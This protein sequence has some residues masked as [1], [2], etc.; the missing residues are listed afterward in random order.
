MKSSPCYE[1]SLSRNYLKV[2]KLDLF[3][4]TY[5]RGKP[6]E[7]RIDG[8]QLGDINL[9]VGKNATGK[10]RIVR[11]IY[12][13]SELL[14]DGGKLGN[15]PRKYEWH[16]LF[17][18][19]SE[20]QTGYFLTI[21]NGYITQE[22]LEIGKKIFL[23]R[24]KTGEGTIYA[25]ELNKDI[26]FQ[27]PTTELA[28]VKRRD[29]IQ[30]P[31]L[32]S[33]YQWASSLRFYEFGTQLGKDTIARI[34]KK[35]KLDRSNIDLKN[36]ES[37]I[38]VFMLGKREIGKKFIDKIIEDMKKINYYIETIGTQIP[39]SIDFVELDNQDTLSHFLCIKEKGL[40]AITEQS[41]MSQGM[42]RVLSLLIQINYSLLSSKPSCILIDDI[43]EGL[44]FQRSSAIIKLLIEKAKTGLIKLIMTTNDEN[45]MNGVPLEYW[46]VIE[47]QPGVAK[48]HNYSNSPE[49]FEQFKHIG[50]NNFDFFAS[51]FYL[52]KPDSEE[53]ID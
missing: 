3:E 33:I 27:T 12:L 19:D 4:Y 28:V 23:Q 45:I 42:F 40:S 51:E 48:L 52:Q 17:D 21:K 44:D 32:E 9:I 34:P 47:R 46:S 35:T 38:T 22:K 20:H 24:D 11:V 41:E 6:S 37:V 13:L 10:S 49:Q 39:S 26:R 43:G 18:K 36:Y 5:N 14:C 29:T 30:H 25:K 1:F 8:C 15:R 50:L 16:L 2:M 31:F 53:V 7:W